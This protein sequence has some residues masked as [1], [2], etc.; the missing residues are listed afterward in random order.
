MNDISRKELTKYVWAFTLGDGWLTI[1]TGSRNAH[2]GLHQIATHKDYI[3]WQSDILS[4]LTAV[5]YREKPAY[6]N[7][8]GANAKPSIRIETMNHPFYTTLY[9]RIYTPVRVKQISPHDLKLLDW[10]CL[11]ILY[12]DD[13]YIEVS[14]RVTMENYVRV[15]IATDNYSY[16][17]I[18]LL[19]KAIYEKTNI[20]FD[21]QRRKL[22]T[23]YG[24]RLQARKEYA[25]RFID[26][27]TPYVKL[28]F[29]YKLDTDTITTKYVRKNTPSEIEG[30]EIV[31]S[32]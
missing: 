30:D 31:L 12:Q 15:R 7:S 26:G 4:E 23:T 16:G 1:N 14:D 18:V 32:V 29:A 10:E 24:Y 9:E 13:G 11:A 6:I 3:D 2:Y 19:Q 20:P 27:I 21:I 22:A 5:R 28:S 17:D 25:R 8:Q